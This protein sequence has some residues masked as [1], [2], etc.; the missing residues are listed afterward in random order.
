MEAIVRVHHPDLDQIDLLDAGDGPVLR[1]PQADAETAQEAVDLGADR[2]AHGAGARWH[3]PRAASSN[4]D[5]V[6]WACFS[7]RRSDLGHRAGRSGEPVVHERLGDGGVSVVQRPRRRTGGE[8]PAVP[9]ASTICLRRRIRWSLVWVH[10]LT[11]QRATMRWCSSQ[12]VGTEFDPEALSTSRAGMAV[13]HTLRD[14]CFGATNPRRVSRRKRR[15]AAALFRAPMPVRRFGRDC[16]TTN[17]REPRMFSRASCT[18][19]APRGCPVGAGGVA[20]RSSD[21]LQSWSHRRVAPGALRAGAGP[22]LP[23]RG[24]TSTGTTLAFARCVPERMLDCP[25]DMKA[26]ARSSGL[27]DKAVDRRRR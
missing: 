14:R 26:Q 24:R 7:S 9:D 22:A 1:V 27:S 25:E 23:L 11:P 12:V 4:E 21:A 20:R 10:R 6:F 19:F 17:R 3:G 2:L 8:C 16:S 18:P 5:P 13:G 15:A